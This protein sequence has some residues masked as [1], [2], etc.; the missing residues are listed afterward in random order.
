[1]LNKAFNGPVKVKIRP[2]S[3]VRKC[4]LRFCEILKNK[5]AQ[6][7]NNVKWV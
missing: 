6:L 1:M 3:L 4:F 5:H 2:S 7:K